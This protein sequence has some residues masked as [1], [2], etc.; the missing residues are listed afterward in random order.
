[1]KSIVLR[2]NESNMQ[3]KIWDF[4]KKFENSGKFGEIQEF[5][6]GGLQPTIPIRSES[7]FVG[8]DPGPNPD[9]GRNW[10]HDPVRKKSRRDSKMRS[11]PVE[12]GF[13]GT[14]RPVP[15]LAGKL[16]QAASKRYKRNNFSL[17][18]SKIAAE[19]SLRTCAAKM[20]TLQIFS[21]T[22]ILWATTYYVPHLS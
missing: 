11:R 15:T 4:G 21:K 22:N 7:G 3:L 10:D 16:I 13:S 12:F 19:Y 6:I 20:S 18:G 8:Y 17:F 1:M 5:G 9:T 14:G 2:N